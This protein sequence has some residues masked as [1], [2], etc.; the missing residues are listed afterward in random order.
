MRPLLFRVLRFSAVIA[1][2]AV[3]VF[4]SPRV[5]AQHWQ[6]V[7]VPPGVHIVT[8]YFLNR[9]YG[10]IYTP[11]LTSAGGPVAQYINRQKG[12]QFDG[13]VDPA[14]VYRT[15]DGGITW[16]PV[17]IGE[18]ANQSY[19]VLLQMR[20]VSPSHGYLVGYVADSTSG[21]EGGLYETTDS[22]MD[23]NRISPIGMSFQSLCISDSFVF[24]V[25]IGKPGTISDSIVIFNVNSRTFRELPGVNGGVSITSN[26]STI[27]YSHHVD[28]T[29]RSSNEGKTWTNAETGDTTFESWSLY[30]VK[31][32]D[33]V[34]RAAEWTT[35]STFPT[36]YPALS[37]IQLSTDGGASWSA[38]Y[39]FQSELPAIGDVDGEGCTIYVEQTQAAPDSGLLR[40]T[41]MG[42]TW[43]NVGGP[44]HTCDSRTLSVSESGAVVYAAENDGSL[45]GFPDTSVLETIWKTTDGGDGFFNR[46]DTPTITVGTIPIVSACEESKTSVTLA[47]NSCFVNL[48]IDSIEGD[49]TIFSLDSLPSFPVILTG[50]S[51]SSFNIGF[52]PNLHPGT[53]IDS[54]RIHAS[55][56]GQTAT[57]DTIITVT[58]TATP[59]PPNLIPLKSSLAFRTVTLCEG[60]RG[61]RY[62]H[63]LHQPGL[64]AG[65]DYEPNAYRFR[66][67]WP[68][69]YAAHHRSSRRFG[70]AGISFRSS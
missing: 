24:L 5:F 45:Y 19:A 26:G 53:F 8:P 50:Q 22:G 4:N 35:I 60:I 16:S 56:P 25:N 52:K 28:L 17:N 31:G 62:I 63:H 27:V 40:S 2:F 65:Y 1:A 30:A 46:I 59:V 47:Y 12:V 55:V 3:V 67:Y 42:E 58:A 15:L 34:V 14:G 48:S 33:I 61:S 21:Y 6:Q 66:L 36:N 20:F 11:G 64:R 43:Q 18:I 49:T 37:N 38:P 69:R 10:F 23:W 39:I 7:T 57:L 51:S 9:D 41:D 29:M 54:V 13:Q 32:T 68:E 44:I 70:D